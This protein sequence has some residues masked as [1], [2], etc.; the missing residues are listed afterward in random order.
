MIDVTEIDMV[1]FAKAAYALSVPQGLGFF[2]SEAGS[3]SDEEAQS[4][5]HDGELIMD[6]VLGRSI[7]MQLVFTGRKLVD[8]KLTDGTLTAP[9]P[10]YDHTDEKYD[11]LLSQFNISRDEKPPH[12]GCCNCEKCQPNASNRDP[13]KVFDEMINVPEIRK[14]WDSKIAWDKTGLR[15][16]R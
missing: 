7:K 16:P 14:A 8:G 10:W 2:D 5:I 12:N 11:E 9:N 4:C 1:A 15:R 13:D 3:I 6:H